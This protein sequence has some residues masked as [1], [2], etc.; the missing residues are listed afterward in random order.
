MTASVDMLAKHRGLFGAMST[1]LRILRT[2]D[3]TIRPRPKVEE[4]PLAPSGFDDEDAPPKPQAKA[5]A[6]PKATATVRRRPQGQERCAAARNPGRRRPARRRGVREG[7]RR[8]LHGEG[9][10][11]IGSAVA[12]S[13]SE[14]LTNCHV[15]GD[16]TEVTIVRDQGGADGQGRVDERRRRPLRAAGRRP[17]CRNGS[18]SGPTT[19]SRSANGRVTIG[20]PQGLEL[21]VAEGIVSSKRSLNHSR[22]D[23]DLGADLAGLVRR[24]AVRCPAANCSASRPSTSRPART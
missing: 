2:P 15:V 18:A 11:R 22:A 24:R 6:K 13:D 3:P 20:T 12:I 10:P 8:G 1:S 23:P 7:G 9:R 19:T 5:K 14:L 16:S 4:L 21:T 17:S